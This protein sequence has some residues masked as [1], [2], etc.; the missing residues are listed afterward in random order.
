MENKRHNIS[1]PLLMFATTSVCTGFAM[2]SM[3][4]IKEI[5]KLFLNNR[6]KKLNKRNP[7]KAYKQ[8]LMKCPNGGVSGN[9][10]HS[11][12]NNRSENGRYN[13]SLLAQYPYL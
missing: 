13:S 3:V 5:T 8:T 9:I 6:D 11:M 12:A 1:S 2:N 10:C 4:A 7:V